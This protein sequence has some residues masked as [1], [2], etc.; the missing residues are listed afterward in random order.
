M[1]Q[2]FIFVYSFFNFIIQNDNLENINSY[3][4]FKIIYP[5]TYPPTISTPI[6]G[7]AISNPKTKPFAGDIFTAQVYLKK[8]NFYPQNK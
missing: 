5:A 7:F 1:I 2:Q 8:Y 3:S 4:P 6:I